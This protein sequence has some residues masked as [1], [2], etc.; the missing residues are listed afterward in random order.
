MLWGLFEKMLFFHMLYSGFLR[1]CGNKE[2]GNV[3]F[4]KKKW[5]AK[6][7]NLIFKE[8]IEVYVNSDLSEDNRMKKIISA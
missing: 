1:S 5:F 4:K 3:T 8:K 6:Q 2:R 7:L